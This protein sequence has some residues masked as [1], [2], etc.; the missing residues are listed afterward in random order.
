MFQICFGDQHK[1]TQR[2]EDPS[3]EQEDSQHNGK[4]PEVEHDHRKRTRSGKREGGGFLAMPC[5][6]VKIGGGL[7]ETN[8][9]AVEGA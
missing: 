4:H 3:G 2:E 8:T 5:V 1:K 7:N 9:S 6:H